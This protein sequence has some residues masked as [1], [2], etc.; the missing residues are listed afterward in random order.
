MNRNWKILLSIICFAAL[1]WAA[2]HLARHGKYGWTLFVM[3]PVLAGG[4]GTWSLQPRTWGRAIRIGALIG[5]L[6][7]ALFLLT[8][9][10]GYIC[11]LMALPIV[12]PLAIVGSLLAYWGGGL[13]SSKQPAAMCL[14]LPISMLFDVN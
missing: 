11:V 12:V 6:G 1:L 8:G 9:R 5:A 10:E 4:L 2:L 14:L 13:S 3:L 7:C